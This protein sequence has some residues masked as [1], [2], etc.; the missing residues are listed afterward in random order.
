MG[1]SGMRIPGHRQAVWQFELPSQE[2]KQRGQEP[3]IFPEV[4]QER[5]KE[6][7][8]LKAI[9]SQTSK[10]ESESIQMLL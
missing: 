9:S 2:H 7:W 4:R 10:M 5:K 3:H 6:D 1:G 8:V